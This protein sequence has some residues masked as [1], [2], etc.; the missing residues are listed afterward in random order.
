MSDEFHD[1]FVK[2]IEAKVAELETETE[3]L[4]DALSDEGLDKHIKPYRE[5]LA[6]TEAKVRELEKDRERLDWLEGESDR[7]FMITDVFAA[8][9]FNWDR[10]NG[11]ATPLREAIDA[12]RE[13]AQ[14]ES[15]E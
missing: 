5:A 1:E 7:E 10:C 12:A 11:K 6:A 14:G 13:S 4:R 3:R 15:D 2:D 8:K 9:V